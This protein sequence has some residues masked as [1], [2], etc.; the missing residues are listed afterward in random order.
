V[1]V[2]QKGEGEE[3][4]EEKGRGGMMYLNTVIRIKY[5]YDSSMLRPNR[6]YVLEVKYEKE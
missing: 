6:V 1:K 4:E 2:V 3:K 5:Y